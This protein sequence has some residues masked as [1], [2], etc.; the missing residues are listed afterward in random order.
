M[1]RI[2]VTAKADADIDTIIASLAQRAGMVT[3]EKYLRLFDQV[4]ERL[5]A[6][7][8]SG[9]A[10]KRLGAHVRIVPVTPFVMIYDWEPVADTVI[11][12]RVVR[13]SRRIMRRGLRA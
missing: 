12:L 2:V 3:V 8:G 7:P 9:F 10:R 5:A 1:A 4:Y 11:M 13:G 6:H